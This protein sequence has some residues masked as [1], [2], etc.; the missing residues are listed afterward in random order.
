MKD[1]ATFF[2]AARAAASHGSHPYFLLAGKGADPSNKGLLK[3]VKQYGLRERVF[4]LGPR[5][6]INS[7]LNATDILALSSRFGEGFPNILGEAMACGVPC[8]ATNVGDS[9][10]IIGDTGRIVPPGNARALA[11]A[12]QDLLSLNAEQYANLSKAARSR[13]IA[14]FNIPLVVQQ[15]ERLYRELASRH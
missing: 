14:N 3:L 2:K 8:V 11:A 10:S 4:L 5:R 9:A 15:Y 1:H 13:I 12:M 6:D 7:I